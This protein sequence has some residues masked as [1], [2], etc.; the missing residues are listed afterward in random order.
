M[1]KALQLFS[2]GFF[3]I[4]A[5][6]LADRAEVLLESKDAS[7]IVIDEMSGFL[8]CFL[9]LPLNLFVLLVG[10]V[11]FRFFDIVKPYPIDVLEKRLPGGWGIVM[12]D[13]LAGIFTNICL[14]IVARFLCEA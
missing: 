14:R 1:K 3:L 4:A 6:Y 2:V 12:D 10:F 13:V 8:V 11:L 7:F 9:W 5:V